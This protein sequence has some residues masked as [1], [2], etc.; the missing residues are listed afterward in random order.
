MPVI[1]VPIDVIIRNGEVS[2]LRS[3]S[4]CSA[5]VQV[6]NRPGVGLLNSFNSPVAR[7]THARHSKTEARRATLWVGLRQVVV[8]VCTLVTPIALDVFLAL[9]RAVALVWVHGP[10][11]VARARLTAWVVSIATL[12]LVTLGPCETLAADT[13]SRTQSLLNMRVIPDA[14]SSG[15]RSGTGALAAWIAMV[16]RH[17]PRAEVTV[18]TTFAVDA[19]SVMRAVLADS[20]T[21]V[22]SKLV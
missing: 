8:A 3:W 6:G 9:A 20:A 2:V 14:A 22:L 16:P 21:V 18:F 10:R 17:T 13:V 4:N 11:V 19:S 15:A 1:H 12:A 5:A 7:S